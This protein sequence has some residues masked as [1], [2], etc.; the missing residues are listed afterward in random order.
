[1]GYRSQVVIAIE[2][3]LFKKNKKLLQKLIGSCDFQ[4]QTVDA[5]YFG[6]DSVRWYDSF[7]EVTQLNDFVEENADRAALLRIGEA[8]GDITQ[9]GDCYKFDLRVSQDIITPDF[10]PNTKAAETLFG[11]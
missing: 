9:L 8:V 1:M 11:E 7:K 2:K 4:N 6:W 10:L 5:V 3:K